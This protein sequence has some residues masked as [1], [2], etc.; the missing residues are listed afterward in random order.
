M[1]FQAALG[2]MAERGIPSLA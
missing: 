2:K 1:E